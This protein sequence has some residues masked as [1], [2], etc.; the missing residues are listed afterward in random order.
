MEQPFIENRPY[1][2]CLNT[3]H[4]TLSLNEQILFQQFSDSVCKQNICIW[5]NQFTSNE[6]NTQKY[7]FLGNWVAM[8]VTHL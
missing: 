7:V 3:L 8:K 6:K 2:K 5:I 1:R 4:A